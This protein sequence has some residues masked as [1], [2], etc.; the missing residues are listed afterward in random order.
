MNVP[1][2]QGNPKDQGE[3]AYLGWKNEEESLYGIRDGYKDAADDLVDIALQKGNGGNN[4]KVLDTYIYP[5]CFLYRHSIEI[6][7]KLIYWRCYH[8]LPD[9]VHDLMTL[10]KSVK[11]EVIRLLKDDDFINQIKSY[12]KDFHKYDIDS[13]QIEDLSKSIES[14]NK[15]DPISDRYRYLMNTK[16]ILYNTQSSFIDYSKLKD[17]YTD[18]YEK[19]DF[20]YFVTD[21]YLSS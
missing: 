14:I 11:N 6:S 13:I 5:I 4:I 17:F 3:I 2:I 1:E 20:V 9:H 15:D 12:K 8:K 16:N 21:E 10:F 18:I 7:L 19:L